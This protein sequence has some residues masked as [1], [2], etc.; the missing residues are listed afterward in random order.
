MF[1]ILML[2]ES[3]LDQLLVFSNVH[4]LDLA[5]GLAG[6]T[7]HIRDIFFAAGTRNQRAATNNVLTARRHTVNRTSRNIAAPDIIK[8][9]H[10]LGR[11]AGFDHLLDSGVIISH[12]ASFITAG[13]TTA[14]IDARLV[15]HVQAVFLDNAKAGITH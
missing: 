15:I 2:A 8:I 4:V 9:I 3:L 11:F 1:S 7:D 10:G 13:T 5:T 6:R 14:L 12:T